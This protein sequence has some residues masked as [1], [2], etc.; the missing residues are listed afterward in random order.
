MIDSQRFNDDIEAACGKLRNRLGARGRSLAAQL[1][2]AGRLLPKPARQAGQRLVELQPMVAHPSLRRLVKRDEIKA[3]LAELN[4]HLDK[5]S[6]AERRKDRQLG[7]AGSVVGNLLLLGV[8][9][10]TFMRWRGL[11]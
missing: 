6:G 3:A 7:L 1:R 11:I 8:L 10:I 2:R 4:D 5:V 9:L